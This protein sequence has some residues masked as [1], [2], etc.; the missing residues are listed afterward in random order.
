MGKQADKQTYKRESDYGGQE[1]RESKKGWIVEGWSR[2]QGN[3]T[4]YKFL[5]PYENCKV[6][7]GEN[8]NDYYFKKGEMPGN[9]YNDCTKGEYL[10]HNYHIRMDNSYKAIR[11]LRSGYAVQ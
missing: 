1:I 9:P 5:I 10:L 7:K 11:V 4:D 8:L 2:Y 6:K 3:Q